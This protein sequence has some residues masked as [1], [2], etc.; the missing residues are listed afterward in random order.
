MMR[1]DIVVI[2]ETFIQVCFKFLG[3]SSYNMYF[4]IVIA[5]PN[6]AHVSIEDKDM[7]LLSVLLLSGPDSLNS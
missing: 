3:F 7:R 4:F 6:R 5:F 1:I 2:W